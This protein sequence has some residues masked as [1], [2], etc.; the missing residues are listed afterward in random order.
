MVKH[1][2]PPKKNWLDVLTRLSEKGHEPSL[3]GERVNGP[4]ASALQNDRYV[5][6]F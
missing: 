3:N 1:E 6:K 5:Y 4:W 2:G